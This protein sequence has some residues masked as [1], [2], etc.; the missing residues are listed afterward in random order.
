MAD[1]TSLTSFTTAAWKERGKYIDLPEGRVFVVELDAVPDEGATPVLVLHGFPTSS[2]DFA[3]ASSL[4]ARHRKVVLFDFIGFGFSDKPRDA[5]YGLFEQADVALVVAR[6]LGIS[7]AHVWSHDMGTSVA[8]ELCARRER[9]LLPF[10]M[11]SLV[12]MNGSVHIEM[13]SLTL[14]QHL[15][16]SPVADLFARVSTKRVFCAQMKRI[17]GRPPRQA[18][19]DGMWELIERDEGP[20]RLP[21]IIQY[22][23]ERTRFRRRWI[24]ALERFDVPTLVGWG[25][26][27]PI[28]AL[29]IAEQLTREIQRSELT[30]WSDLGHYPQVEDPE[31]VAATVS[32]FWKRVEACAT[33]P[34]VATSE[35]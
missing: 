15:L 21:A 24:G 7:R 34:R 6:E 30:L 2:W 1:H 20:R 17:F 31:T 18:D 10:E 4:V 16:L 5:G 23:R 11:E 22:V 26:K 25:T 8:T 9:G 12:L 27:D 13:A 29:A 19:L 28:C 33:R 3:E 14:G 32:A 35:Q